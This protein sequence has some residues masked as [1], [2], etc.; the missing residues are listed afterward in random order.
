MSSSHEILIVDDDEEQVAY[1]SQILENN[2]LGYT[3]AHNGVEAL[4]K[5]QGKPPSLVLLDIM[6]PRKSGVNVLHQMKNPPDLASIPVIIITGASQV[7]GV[8]MKTG[9][10]KPKESY[11]DDFARSFGETL[12]EELQGLTPD[13][14]IEKPVDPNVLMTKIRELLP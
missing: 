14:F 13:A 7:L 1:I 6:M 11:D 10:M 4:A 9:E 12:R 8:N 2:G 3:V 5:M